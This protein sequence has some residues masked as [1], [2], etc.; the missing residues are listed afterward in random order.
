MSAEVGKGG[1]YIPG[2][3]KGTR[4]DSDPVPGRVSV[5]SPCHQLQPAWL[6]SQVGQGAR[7]FLGFLGPLRPPVSD[8][9][10]LEM[11]PGSG[12]WL[13]LAFISTPGWVIRHLT[14]HPLG[15]SHNFHMPAVASPALAPLEVA[16][17]PPCVSCGP[18]T[19]GQAYT[20]ALRP[21]HH[22]GP[23]LLHPSPAGPRG[24]G[25]VGS[26]QPEKQAK[27]WPTTSSLSSHTCLWYTGCP[28]GVPGPLW[29]M[30]VFSSFP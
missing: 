17:S 14:P 5:Q 3:N 18:H 9:R 29:N 8:V 15:P 28:L 26:R 22:P 2:E 1:P 25:E 13:P 20:C 12:A 16:L 24:G 21:S 19:L 23:F 4:Q 6:H 7:D 27:V 10:S 30:S 11:S